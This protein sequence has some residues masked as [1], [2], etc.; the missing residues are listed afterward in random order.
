MCCLLGA[1][2]GI[3]GLR[4]YAVVH[5][6][7]DTGGSIKAEI[8]AQGLSSMLWEAGSV[9]GIAAVVYLLAPSNESSNRPMADIDA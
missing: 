2:L 1:A 6:V 5:A 8:V 9:L 3:V 7:A 4:I